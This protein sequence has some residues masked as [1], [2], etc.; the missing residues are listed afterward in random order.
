MKKLA[1]FILLFCVGGN[2]WAFYDFCESPADYNTFP[3]AYDVRTEYWKDIP[4]HNPEN[5]KYKNIK[6]KNSVSPFLRKNKQNNDKN[7]L[8]DTDK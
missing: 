5:I 3:Q 6:N 2:A 8:E 4:N 1:V 7:N